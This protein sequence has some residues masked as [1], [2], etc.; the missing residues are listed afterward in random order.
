MSLIPERT[1]SVNAVRASR[2]AEEALERLWPDGLQAVKA[3]KIPLHDAYRHALV[4]LVWDKKANYVPSRPARSKHKRLPESL[5]TLDGAASWLGVSTKTVTG[6][7]RS[8]KLLAANI[9][10]GKRPVYRIT[11]ANLN[12]FIEAQTTEGKPCPSTSKPVRHTGSQKFGSRVIE[13]EG[14]LKELAS[15]KRK[16]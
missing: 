12:R 8:G 6:Y 16:L 4:S 9:G 11:L 15:A 10:T 3:G 1:D 5:F 2:Y 13:L 7:I 14:R